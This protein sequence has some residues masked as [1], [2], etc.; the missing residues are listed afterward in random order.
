MWL[1]VNAA[2]SRQLEERGEAGNRRLSS[3]QRL[4]RLAVDDV[5]PTIQQK[6]PWQCEPAHTIV[7][8][9]E[10][11]LGLLALWAALITLVTRACAV[12]ARCKSAYRHYRIV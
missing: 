6:V 5:A 8:A 2:P 4:R 12:G 9:T 10:I 11:V 7:P 1:N 3:G